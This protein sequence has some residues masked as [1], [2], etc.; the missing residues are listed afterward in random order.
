[1]HSKSLRVGI[2]GAGDAAAV[3]IPG[4]RQVP[5]VELVAIASADG[6]QVSAAAAR[7][8]IPNYYDDYRLMFRRGGLDAVSISA[9]AELHHSVVIAA[10]E[11]GLHILCDSPMA[12]SGAEARDMHRIARDAQVQGSIVFPSRFI[13]ARMRVKQLVDGGYVGDLQSIS[14][15]AFRSPYAPSRKT[16]P[17]VP[18]LS[19][20]QQVGYDYVDTLRWWFGEVYAVAGAR[21]SPALASVEAE[22]ADSNFSMLLQFGSGAVAAIHACATTPVDLGDEIVAIGTDGLIAL[23]NDGK[24][25]GTKR[26]EQSIREL[27]SPDDP[28]SE[29]ERWADPRVGPFSKL[30]S[31][32]AEGILTGEA[33]APTFED[34]MKVQEIVDG[35]MKSQDLARWVDTSGKKW[36]V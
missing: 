4:M 29:T 19:L 21:T 2:V 5:H 31:E 15:T 26:G 24:V 1:M 20:M 8:Q 17:L 25:F 33:T 30:A 11:S 23:R 9:P 6:S 14:V 34:G 28:T 18:R 16:V 13:P 10:V 35:A 7:Y 36:P 22:Q 3:H 32:W 27:P 12:R